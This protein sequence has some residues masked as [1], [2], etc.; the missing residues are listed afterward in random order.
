MNNKQIL[1]LEDYKEYK[2]G[3]LLEDFH[4]TVNGILDKQGNF[5]KKENFIFLTEKLS[6]E[7]ETKVRELIKEMLRL[8]L[9]R[10][11]T[12]NSLLVT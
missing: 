4:P 9:W 11:Y 7:D 3:T 10:L 1:F 5:I 8:F 2:K 6:R 12:R